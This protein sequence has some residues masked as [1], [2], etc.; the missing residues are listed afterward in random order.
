MYYSRKNRA[1]RVRSV[2][3]M[4]LIGTE[5]STL[6]SLEISEIVLDLFGKDTDCSD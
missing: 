4:Y 5:H 2:S 6:V 1:N 3:Y